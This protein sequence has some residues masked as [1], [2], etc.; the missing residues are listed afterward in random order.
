MRRSDFPVFL[1][2]LSRG[3]PALDV[4]LSHNSLEHPELYRMGAEG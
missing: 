2:S 3:W 4:E 1:I